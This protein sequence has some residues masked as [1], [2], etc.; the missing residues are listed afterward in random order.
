[1]GGPSK[2]AVVAKEGLGGL[3]K[4][5]LQAKAK[6]V[7][8]ANRRQR[9][10]AE[11]EADETERRLKDAAIGEAVMTAVPGLRT[12]R[13]RQE[14]QQRAAEEA[15]ERAEQEELAAR[16]V[17]TLELRLEG[18]VTGTWRG[19]VPALLEVEPPAGEDAPD[20]PY[21]SAATLVV[22]LGPLTD[23]TAAPGGRRLGGWRFEVPGYTGPGRY[24]LAESG[25]RRREADAEPEYIDWEL[26]FGDDE[27]AFYFQPD[28]GPSAVVVG[29]GAGHLDITMA[30][31]GASGQIGVVATLELPPVPAD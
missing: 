24:D 6:E 17:G 28:I 9:E 22:D 14:E 30:M 29:P 5:W 13:D 18:A 15:R 8:T 11:Y 19:T 3:A 31:T 2:G 23:S 12:W 16:P 7:T 26:R 27:E 10:S 21:A 25:M 4:K 20:D 1:M